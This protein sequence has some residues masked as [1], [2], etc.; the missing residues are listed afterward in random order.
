MNYGQAQPQLLVKLRLKAEL[1]LM[2]AYTYFIFNLKFP[3][4]Y[5]KINWKILSNTSEAEMYKY[6]LWKGLH[7]TNIYL[8]TQVLGVYQKWEFKLK[9][10]RDIK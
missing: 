10:K 3:N 6:Q 9:E 5:N 4:V 2:K 1:A 7:S 8:Q